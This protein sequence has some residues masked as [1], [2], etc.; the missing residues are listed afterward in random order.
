[1]AETITSLGR[2]WLL[3]EVTLGGRREEKPPSAGTTSELLPAA[4]GGVGQDPGLTSKPVEST[5]E[6]QGTGSGGHWP[7]I[8]LC[9]QVARAFSPHPLQ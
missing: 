6:H 4:G 9:S 5:P 7:C 3:R 8:R 2:R 1:M